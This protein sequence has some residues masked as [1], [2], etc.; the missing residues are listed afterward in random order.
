MIRELCFQSEFLKIEYLPELKSL[1]VTKKG[2]MNFATYVDATR[3]T[4]NTIREREVTT[5]IINISE[6][7]TLTKLQEKYMEEVYIPELAHLGIRLVVIIIAPEAY[8]SIIF[9]RL[10]KHGIHFEYCDN[11]NTALEI[12]ANAMGRQSQNLILDREGRE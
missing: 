9:K 11:F 5:R 8:N 10:D 4:L 2:T 7:N 3:I 6:M 12:T 1:Y